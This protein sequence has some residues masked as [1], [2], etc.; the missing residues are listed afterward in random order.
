MIELNGKEC[1]DKY[2]KILKEK[3]SKLDRKL[4]L[5]VIQVGN[6]EASNVYVEQKGKRALELGYNFEH[7]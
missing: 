1:R 3:V 2:L 7:K 4:G 5:L 6:N